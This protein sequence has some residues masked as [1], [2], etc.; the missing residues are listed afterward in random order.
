MKPPSE[1]P[2]S[3]NKE[4]AKGEETSES[5]NADKGEPP[6]GDGALSPQ[7]LEDRQLDIALESREVEKILG[8]LNGVTD[9]AKERS[10]TTL[11]SGDQS[12]LFLKPLAS[13]GRVVIT[14]TEPDL[15]VNEPIFPHKLAKGLDDPPPFVELDRDTDGRL[16]LLDLYLWTAREVAQEYAMGELLAT[17]HALLDDTADGRG[18]EIQIDYLPEELGG[19]LCRTAMP[20]AL[21]TLGTS[22]S[23]A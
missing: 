5:R 23:V 22:G 19:R 7:E 14:A 16:S 11:S 20:Q 17:E 1:S 6:A 15:E 9:L 18:T 12:G 3:E 8:R 2:I 13:P 4:S 21:D 10:R